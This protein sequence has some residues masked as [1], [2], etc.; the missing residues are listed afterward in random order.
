MN[1]GPMCDAD[2][3][4]TALEKYKVEQDWNGNYE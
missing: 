4:V 1:T 3:S 2:G